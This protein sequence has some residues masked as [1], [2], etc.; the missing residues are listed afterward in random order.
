M[1]VIAI[2]PAR[3]ASTRLEAKLI[4]DLAGKSVLNRTYEQALK[5]KLVTRV[6]IATDSEELFEHAKEFGAEVE[7]TSALHQSGSDR[8]AEL[9]Q[10]NP[11]WGI[12]VNVQGDEPFIN[13]DDID[14]AIEPFLHDPLLEMTSLYHSISDPEEIK[15]P[16]NVKVVIDQNNNA[17]YFSRAAIP[18]ER[19]Q[20]SGLKALDD[21]ALS[22]TPRAYKKHIGL[23]AY[24]RDTLIK[25]T[26]LPQSELEK[27]EKLEQLRALENGIKIKMLEVKSSPI[28][29][30]TEEDY[31]KALK[32]VGN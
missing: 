30:D 29:I 14:K 20:G 5:S 31:Q 23:Y 24:R 17:L 4:K 10:K 28:G 8:I 7:M 3:L 16:N 9:A 19:V 21:L 2:I 26:S 22:P 6:V 27:L 11:D 32:L 25:L 12:I 18:F 13:P 15:N 1:Q